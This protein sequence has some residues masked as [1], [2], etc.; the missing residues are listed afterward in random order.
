MC[1]H[2]NGMTLLYKHQH[3]SGSSFVVATHTKFYYN[4]YNRALQWHINVLVL[5]T[6]YHLF[7]LCHFRARYIP[8]TL[9]LIQNIGVF[10]HLR[11]RCH[12]Q[13]CGY[14]DSS[15]LPQTMASTMTTSLLRH[16]KA[17][18]S[19][20]VKPGIGSVTSRWGSYK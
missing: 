10:E 7:E 11:V 1:T 12:R 18:T 8:C 6:N 16:G 14:K 13:H 17:T 20:V 5:N 4:E 19:S 2:F 15:L 9:L 3:G